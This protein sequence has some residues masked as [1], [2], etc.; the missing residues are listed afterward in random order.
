[1][2]ETVQV[3]EG[4]YPYLKVVF[5]PIIGIHLEGHN[6]FLGVKSILDMKREQDVLND[7]LIDLNNVIQKLNKSRALSTPRYDRNFFHYDIQHN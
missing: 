2:Y 5:C 3:V 6:D 7:T 1:M 4:K